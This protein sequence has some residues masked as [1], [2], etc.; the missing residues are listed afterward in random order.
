MYLC[1]LG[2]VVLG[3]RPSRQRPQAGPRRGFTLLELVVVIGIIMALAGILTLTLPDLLTSANNAT[4]VSNIKECDDMIQ[5]WATTHRGLYPDG[6]S[7]LMNE[8]GSGLYSLLPSKTVSGATVV[9]GGYLTP[10]DLTDAQAT[11]LQRAGIKNVYN[12]TATFQGAM[13]AS[14]MSDNTTVVPVAKGIKLAFVTAAA[15]GSYPFS[16]LPGNKMQFVTGRQ[17]VVLGIGRSSELVGVGGLIKDQPVIV[18]A[19]GCTSPKTTYCVPCAIF[20]LGT[21]T[22]GRG[23]IGAAKFVGCVALADSY[24][25]F[26]EEFST[27]Y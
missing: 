22:L 8:T 2:Q 25:R 21:G 26:S 3:G 23:S 1:K 4:M 13:G 5:A 10:Q 6:L 9:V 12:L 7:S 19:E 17:Y 16:V 15:D 24:F 27:I 18:H 14:Y 20:D 11:L